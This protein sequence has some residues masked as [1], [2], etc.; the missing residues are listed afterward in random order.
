M[1]SSGCKHEPVVPNC[2]SIQTARPNVVLIMVDDLGQECLESYGG[3]SYSTPNLNRLAAEGLQFKN[4]YATY[5]CHTTRAQ[6]MTGQY[7]FKNGWTRFDSNGR[8]F[9]S[10]KFNL[11]RMFKNAGYNTAIVGKWHLCLPQT[12]PN[13]V[14]NCGFDESLV[15]TWKIDGESTSRFWKPVLWEGDE[16]I[17]SNDPNEYGPD[18]FTHRAKQF[19]A[20]NCETPFFLYYPMVLVHSPFVVT[21][22]Q[23]RPLIEDD[24]PGNFRYM[25]EYMDNLVGELMDHLDATGLSDNTL[26]IFTGDNG[27]DELVYTWANGRNIQGGKNS[28]LES[29]VNMPLLVKWPREIQPGTETEELMDFTDII[30]TLAEVA[31]A[32]LP[33]EAELQGTSFVEVLK[34]GNGNRDW[35]YSQY[36]HK[37][38]IKDKRWKL[39][40]ENELYF[41]L[42][43]RYEESP[44]TENEGY[45]RNSRY[46]CYPARLL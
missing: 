40:H 33:A 23:G 43:D 45:P 18:T 36:N 27:T 6:I 8:C 34:G 16:I 46:S 11:G 31:G 30:P 20:K 41:L 1:L 42:N 17:H 37:W 39:T 32:S 13:N 14:L 10:S 44:I 24:N 22:D 5:N 15:W 19:I 26:F 3:Q 7:P 9:D 25:V 29:G 12:D 2:G 35:I 4:A 28:M 38:V 21:P